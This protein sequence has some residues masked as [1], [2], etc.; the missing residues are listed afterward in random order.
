VAFL[1][2]TFQKVRFPNYGTFKLKQAELLLS[3]LKGM[4]AHTCFTGGQRESIKRP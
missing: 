1:F 4:H 3:V 2:N